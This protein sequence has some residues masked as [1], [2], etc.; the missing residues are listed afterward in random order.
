MLE[1]KSPAPAL[2]S[3]ETRIGKAKAT[4]LAL[5]SVMNKAPFNR[6][7]YLLNMFFSLDLFPKAISAYSVPV[8]LFGEQS[9]CC[10]SD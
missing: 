3:C 1:S 7:L 9:K 8:L 5:N 4:Q 2:V 6:C 10:H